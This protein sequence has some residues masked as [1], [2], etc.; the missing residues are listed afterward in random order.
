MNDGHRLEIF[1]R[2]FDG[3]ERSLTDQLAQLPGVDAG[4]QLLEIE[5]LQREV[6]EGSL[7]T[8]GRAD[9]LMLITDWLPSLIESGKLLPIGNP[10]P[11]AWAPAL[12]ELQTGKDGQTYGIAYH[13]GPML[14]LYRT[15]LYADPKEQ[16]GFADR[17]G[18]PLAPPTDW[19]QFR[20]QAVWFDR[21]STGLRGTVLAG[22]PDEH[23][24][25]YDFLTHLW[26]RGGELITSG[27]RSG[28][29]SAAAGE[30][31][32][33]LHGLWHVDRVVDPAAAAWDSVSS[34]VHF[35]AG[36]A[37][38]MVNWC[39]FAA[40]SAD[41]GSPTHGKVGCAPTPG[42]VTMNAYWVLTVPAG[43]RDPERSAE[44]IRRLTTH[45]M[46]VRTAL[47]GGSATRRD[48]WADP[49]VRA[50]A[51]YYDV[52]EQAHQ[53]SRSVPVDPRWPQIAAVLNEMMR[54]VV[55][56]GAG[57]TALDKAHGTL[58]ALLLRTK[59]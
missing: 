27:G 37:A 19:T 50:L 25:V 16:Q 21:P 48:S 42:A 24:N 43:A 17:F 54:A 40:M 7:A 38:M 52:L 26:S 45:D 23:N 11:D 46:D 44:L 59:A 31:V 49:R 47:A 36:E 3:F 22:Y 34:G 1:G 58:D 39:G 14:F 41:P 20:D 10:E 35:A 28:L 9:V 13:D 6:V 2:A 8:D 18:Y 51:P 55:E 32:D 56:E 29:D 57:R 33:F 12:R 15:D 53:H 30:A 5:D 4:Y